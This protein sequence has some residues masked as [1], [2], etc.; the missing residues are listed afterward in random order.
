[1]G[2]IQNRPKQTCPFAQN[3][4]AVQISFLSP[5]KPL[6][7]GTRKRIDCAVIEDYA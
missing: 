2:H 4:D 7:Q 6:N 3:L 1:M 5:S